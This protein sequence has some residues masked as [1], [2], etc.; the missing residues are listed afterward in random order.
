MSQFIL[1][2]TILIYFHIFGS[3]YAIKFLKR[4]IDIEKETKRYKLDYHIKHKA[5]MYIICI[6]FS[7][8]AYSALYRLSNTK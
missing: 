8:I 5:T 1:S 4:T 3:Y 7:W 2:I 6:I